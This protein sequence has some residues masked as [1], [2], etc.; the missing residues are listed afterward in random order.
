MEIGDNCLLS[1]ETRRATTVVPD[2]ATD[3]ERSE[4]SALQYY[5]GQNKRDA[6]S[7]WSGSAS[8]DTERIIISPDF[9]IEKKAHI[10]GFNDDE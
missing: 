6:L 2:L 7:D 10:T 5:S 3:Q 1:V 9:L 4:H 8:L